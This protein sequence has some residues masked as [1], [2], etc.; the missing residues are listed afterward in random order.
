[1]AARHVF[2]GTLIL[3]KKYADVK[4]ADMKLA[5]DSTVYVMSVARNAGTDKNEEYKATAEE[6]KEQ[7]EE[8]EQAEELEE[9]DVAKETEETEEE[10][11]EE[12]EEEEAEEE[13]E[14]VHEHLPSSTKAEVGASSS[15]C[16]W[17]STGSLGLWWNLI[18][19]DLIVLNNAGKRPR[20]LHHLDRIS[21][22]FMNECSGSSI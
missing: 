11:E 9:L 12:A 15:S 6:A 3:D 10:A 22:A 13:A 20:H 5:K 19:T 7:A 4:L 18:A 14:E 16:M 8:T 21:I 2:I 17:T 1:M